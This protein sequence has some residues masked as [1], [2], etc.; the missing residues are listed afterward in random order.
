MDSVEKTDA[1]RIY[2]D[3]RYAIDYLT[4]IVKECE[5]SYVSRRYL[6]EKIRG[7]FNCVSFIKETLVEEK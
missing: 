5:S 7:A 2:D 6:M 1:K 4:A 3:A